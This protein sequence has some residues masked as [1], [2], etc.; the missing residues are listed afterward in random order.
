[1]LLCC[2]G[3]GPVAG[4]SA[5]SSQWSDNGTAADNVPPAVLTALEEAVFGEPFE[6]SALALHP[7]SASLG[8]WVAN[9]LIVEQA[10]H[11]TAVSPSSIHR[12]LS[13]AAAHPG[14]GHPLASGVLKLQLN[15]RQRMAALDCKREERDHLFL[16]KRG[17]YVRCSLVASAL[18][19]AP[20]VRVYRPF[21]LPACC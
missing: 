4:S 7:P 1:M 15:L 19:C 17:K 8:S 11:E 12:G 6:Y 20:G 14:T 5:K 2:S 21:V 13:V 16:K 3:G 10:L 9:R 18:C